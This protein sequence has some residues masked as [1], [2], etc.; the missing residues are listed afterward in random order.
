MS[1]RLRVGV[2]GC[3]A[4]AQIMHLP[5]LREM[6][7]L[8]ELVGLADVSAEV[9]EL[10]GQHYGVEPRHRYRSLSELLAAPIDAVLILTPGS[11]GEACVEAATAD[12]HVFVEKPLAFTMRELDE[13]E[14]AIERA[15][16]TLQVGYMKRYDP[17]YVRAR[18]L[19][20]ALADLRFGQITTVHP[21]SELFWEHQPI[22]RRRGQPAKHRY[23]PPPYPPLA[24]ESEVSD[25]HDARLLREALG[26]NA[27]AAQLGAFNVMLSS[28][29]HD[30]N[31]LRGLIGEPA[32]VVSC[33]VWQRGG[34]ASTVLAY[35]DELRVSYS[36]VYLP[37]LR[38][39]HEELAFFGASERV[40]L[41]FPS[42]FL[43]NMP[44]EL[45]HER[46]DDGAAAETRAIVSYEEAFEEELRAFHRNVTER[47]RPETD[48]EDSRGDL[49]VLTEMAKKAF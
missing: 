39:Y 13:I 7:D 34:C 49:R 30:V 46:S 14:A 8:Y 26:A 17:A 41:V 48:V 27:P 20:R 36:F 31:A 33:E 42:P 12:K 45:F 35:G 10:V 2:A 4:V 24:L 29:C 6:D 32:R 23:A 47:L 16:V 9:L 38:S 44:T 43:R 25:G 37:N 22:R 5:H 19:V 1:Q 15:G 11:H 3:G 21:A 18:P 28:L 40:R